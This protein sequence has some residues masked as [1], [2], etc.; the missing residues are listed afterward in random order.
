M[1]NHESEFKS[2]LG[3]MLIDKGLITDKQLHEALKLQNLSGSR[4]GEILVGKGWVTQRQLNRSLQK[5]SRVRMIATVAAVL[6]GPLQPFMAQAATEQVTSSVQ[7]EAGKS[8]N[9]MRLQ[10]LDDSALGAVSAQGAQTHYNKLLDIV[11]NAAGGQQADGNNIEQIETLTK[12]LFPG[13]DLLEADVEVT[14]VEYAQDNSININQDG[15]IGLKMPTKIQG[16]AFKNIRVKGAEGQHMGD[17]FITG[18][19][20]EGTSVK[21]KI[22][23]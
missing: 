5:Q 8:H 16:L 10:A 3:L 7:V 23:S 12:L 6:L 11:N 22:R 4:L 19:N 14:G 1:S 18:I 13:L 15:S 20:L 9:A 21:V 17:L 2:R